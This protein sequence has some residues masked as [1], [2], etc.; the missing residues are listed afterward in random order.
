LAFSRVR[1][2]LSRSKTARALLHP[3]ILVRR[4]IAQRFAAERKSMIETLQESLAEDPVVHVREFEG[5]FLVDR[6]SHL[7]ARVALDGEYEPVLAAACV[8]NLDPARDAI[9][10]GANV[11]FYTNLLARHVARRRVLAIEPTANALAKLRHNIERNGIGARTVVCEGIVS[12]REGTRTLHT[13]AGKEEYSSLAALAHPSIAG[14][15]FEEQQVRATTIDALVA[16]HELDPG[17]IKIDVEGAEHEVL[18]GAEATLRNARPVVLAELSAELLARNGTS[19]AAVI[20]LLNE[21]E[22]RLVDPLNPG[23]AF[24]A[25][26]YGDVLCIPRERG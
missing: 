15:P 22:Y 24:V 1:N 8:A 17:F 18:R 12:D 11:G 21:L 16:Q 2:S 6:R 9:D 19:A 10:V 13:V 7:F 26:D 20:A 25:R 3:A 23:A 4:A 5:S 14:Q